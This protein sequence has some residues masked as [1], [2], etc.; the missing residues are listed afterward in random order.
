M[1]LAP[2]GLLYCLLVQSSG[3]GFCQAAD[4]LGHCVLQEGRRSFL[5]KRTK[6]LLDSG[7]RGLMGPPQQGKSLLLLFLRKEGLPS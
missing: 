4:G 5:K 2:G 7:V 3:G 1:C 6:K